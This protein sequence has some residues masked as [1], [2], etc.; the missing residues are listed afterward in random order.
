[1]RANPALSTWMRLSRAATPAHLTL[2]WC[3]WNDPLCPERGPKGEGDVYRRE[4]LFRAKAERGRRSRRAGHEMVAREWR[5]RSRRS[6]RG[7]VER[8]RV[9]LPDGRSLLQA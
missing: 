7:P 6:D 5:P 8:Q 1:M 9:P 4:G 3:G 2:E